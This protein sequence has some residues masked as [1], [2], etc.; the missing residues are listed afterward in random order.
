MTPSA[1]PRTGTAED[2]RQRLLAAARVEFAAKGIAGGRVD[3]IAKMSG[4]NKQRIYAHFGSKERLFDAV[5]SQSLD[6]MADAV[7]VAGPIEDYVGRVFE[8]HQNNPEL[9][10][11][12]LW[13]SL[14]YREEPLP[15]DQERTDRYRHKV[16]ALADI[17]GT[18]PDSDTASALL[19]MIGLAAWPLAVPPMTRL[20]LGAA[21]DGAAGEGD[22]NNVR[23]VATEMVRRAFP[24][25]ARPE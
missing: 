18:E 14:H 11:L 5:V 12:I 23:S 22:V 3:S 24:A 1:V 25:G 15:N 20:V 8:F 16:Q 9:L 6:E 13:E 7:P 4:V 21:G 19:L 10:R 2:T 17:L